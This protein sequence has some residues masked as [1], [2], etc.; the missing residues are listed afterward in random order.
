M[1]NGALYKADTMDQI[2]PEKRVLPPLWWW[3][4]GPY[5]K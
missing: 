2:W 5:G 4:D 1:K 3:Q